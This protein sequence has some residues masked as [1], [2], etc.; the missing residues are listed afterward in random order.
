MIGFCIKGKDK[1]L[2]IRVKFSDD[3][4]FIIFEKLSKKNRKR[5]MYEEKES[6]SHGPTPIKDSN[7]I[8]VYDIK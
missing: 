3:G 7:E 2:E 5:G 4:K 1:L 8:H 6:A